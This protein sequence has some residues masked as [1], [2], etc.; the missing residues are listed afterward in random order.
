MLFEP[1]LRDKRVNPV[2]PRHAPFRYFH[3][4]THTSEGHRVIGNEMFSFAA[5]GAFEEIN[6]AYRRD[7]IL[8]DGRSNGEDLG[9]L[10]NEIGPM[11]G[12]NRKSGVEG[13]G[14]SERVDTGG[15][16]TQRNK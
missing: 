8:A 16:S 14:G 2:E 5:I 4:G 13:K 3:N 6:G 15:G 10:P 9:R 12:G 7:A 1:F 11:L